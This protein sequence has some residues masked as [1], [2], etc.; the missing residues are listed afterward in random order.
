[1]AQIRTDF[2][3]DLHQVTVMS[4]VFLSYRRDDSPDA[5]GRIHDRLVSQYG[6]E[7]L[8]MD[9]DNIPPGLD[10]R[11]II[12]EAV[13]RCQ[14]FLA[15]IGPGWIAA[16]DHAGRVR[17]E[18]PADFVRLE[19]EAA[20][21][22]E[23]P[24]IP[25]LVGDAPMPRPEQ[26]PDSLQSLAFRNAINVRRNPD[27]HHDVGRLISWMEKLLEPR[28]PVRKPRPSRQNLA[29]LQD[30]ELKQKAAAESAYAEGE[31]YYHGIGVPIDFAAAAHH[32]REAAELNHAAAQFTLGWLFRN[33]WGVTQD[34][35]EAVLW[36]QKAAAQNHADAQRNMGLAYR[37]GWGVPVD[38]SEALRWFRLA[39]AH[40]LAAAQHNIAVIYEEGLG[41]PKDI[42]EAQRWYRMAAGN[43][44]KKANDA[45]RR[46]TS[47]ASGRKAQEL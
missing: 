44:Y 4:Q 18:N 13:G 2:M 41:V 14:I 43:G 46:L 15:V 7:R 36:Y 17:L 30:V 35:A 9:V 40:N 11:V 25:V 37:Y 33:G 6:H 23:I 5:A 22:R 1:M 19:I 34:Y 47:R 28:K 27:F 31:K 32:Y 8:F 24:V 20:L 16:A 26:L 38:L 45:I 39:A 12:D 3:A 21:N 29:A 42:T 10:F